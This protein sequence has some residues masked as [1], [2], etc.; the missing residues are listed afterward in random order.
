MQF[1]DRSEHRQ[2]V[3]FAIKHRA[4]TLITSLLICGII[5]YIANDF[6][7]N[8][9]FE[10]LNNSYVRNALAISII[11][12]VFHEFKSIYSLYNYLDFKTDL[13]GLEA[14]ST[15]CSLQVCTRMCRYYRSSIDTTKTLINVLKSLSPIPLAVLPE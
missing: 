10:S 4:M 2:N 9:I 12:I 14:E 1:N 7:S 5:V 8:K 13:R 15:L 11:V 6:F 3:I